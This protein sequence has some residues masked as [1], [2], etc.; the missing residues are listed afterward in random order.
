MNKPQPPAMPISLV[1]R[2]NLNG[3]EEDEEGSLSYQGLNFPYEPSRA[4]FRG[5]HWK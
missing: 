3:Q 4:S 1:N 2:S 5:E